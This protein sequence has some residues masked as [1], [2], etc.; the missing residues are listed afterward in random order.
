M[1]AYRMITEAF[2]R[3]WLLAAAI[4]GL[5]ASSIF[6]NRLPV[7]SHTELEVLG[8][9]WLLFAVVRGLEETGLLAAVAVRLEQ[10]RFL[11]AR[12]VLLTFAL[13]ALA[14]NDAALAVI[15]PLTLRLDTPGRGWL[16]ILEAL[17]A[18]AGSALTPFGNPQNIHVFWHYGLTLSRFV[19]VIAPFSL[20]SLALILFMAWLAPV[21][22]AV[23][24]GERAPAVSRKACLFGGLFG[25][26]ILVILRIAPLGAGLAAALATAAARRSLRVDYVLLLTFAVFFA[27]SGNIQ[28]M[29]GREL[30]HEAHS[31]LLPALSSQIMSNVPAAMV[32]SHFT[33][34]WQALLWGVNAGG[35]GTLIASFANLIAWRHYM[36]AQPDGRMRRAF[37]IRFVAS[38]FVMLAAS[39]IFY[40]LWRTW[41][42][43]PY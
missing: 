18:N 15:V 4:L 7:L 28:A 22:P 23:P 29:I 19:T 43:W 38:G 16:V 30:T 13:A 10:G 21:R 3:E 5:A 8:L 33:K 26:T 34:D 20:F 14:T 1:P 35:Y 11:A 9:L 27:L 32:F 42:L 40:W 6:L 24:S 39:A 37:T 31:F 25:V 41:A 17:A 36:A 2:R 12:L